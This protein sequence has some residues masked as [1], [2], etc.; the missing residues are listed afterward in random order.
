MSIETAFS[1]LKGCRGGI[2]EDTHIHYKDTFNINSELIK[3]E[4]WGIFDGHCGRATSEFLEKESYIIFKKHC[5]KC[6]TDINN[7]EQIK[8]AFK[9]AQIEWQIKSPNNT[10]NGSTVIFSLLICDSMMTYNLSIGDGRFNYFYKDSGQ[11]FE[12]DIKFYDFIDGEQYNYYGKVINDIHQINGRLLKNGI[13]ISPYTQINKKNFNYNEYTIENDINNHDFN[14]WVKFNLYID[15]GDFIC[16][17]KLVANCYRLISL[18]PTRTI[19]FSE[20]S[21]HLGTMM[22][23]KINKQIKACL[24]CDG[25]DDNNAILQN[26]LPMIL[27]DHNIIIN[28][29]FTNHIAL[30]CKGS[31]KNIPFHINILEKIIWIRD[32]FE[33]NGHL[34]QFDNDWRIGLDSCIKFFESFDISNIK[35]IQQEVDFIANIG[36]ARMSGDNITLALID[37]DYNDKSEEKDINEILD[38]IQEIDEITEIINDI[39]EINEITEVIIDIKQIQQINKFNINKFHGTTNKLRSINC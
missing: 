16:I 9:C 25:L 36:V 30:K 18:Q 17:P 4:C 29:F 24:C 33:G 8:N 23:F 39:K 3:I 35:N 7:Y 27:L 19:G 15:N 28:E 20:K 12:T 31:P 26:I 2:N 1:S 14:E 6:I 32:C 13:P 5:E 10:V 21:L 22:S 37:F 34:K 38:E 11:I